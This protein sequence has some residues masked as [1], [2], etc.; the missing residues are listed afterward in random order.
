VT[1]VFDD[2]RRDASFDPLSAAR[3]EIERAVDD[4]VA[5]PSTPPL[6]PP[7]STPTPEH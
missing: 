2:V 7:L 3:K 5:P 6:A 4:A 1:A